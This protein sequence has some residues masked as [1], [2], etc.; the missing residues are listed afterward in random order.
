[1]CVRR[2]VAAARDM[3]SVD[4]DST[5]SS[6]FLGRTHPAERGRWTG[7]TPSIGGYSMI[8]PS[9]PWRQLVLPR[10]RGRQPRWGRRRGRVAP[11]QFA[12][13]CASVAAYWCSNVPRV[14]HGVD[15]RCAIGPTPP[16]SNCG[17][18]H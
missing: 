7:F 13:P 9:D 16:Q 14:Y 12:S 15:F 6:P 11:A 2:A 17:Q 4:Y 1:V 18:P 3:L 10:N 8:P 5:S